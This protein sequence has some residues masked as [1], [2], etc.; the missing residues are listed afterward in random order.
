MRISAA[1]PTIVRIVR[2]LRRASPLAVKRRRLNA[3]KLID[4][5]AMLYSE[6]AGQRVDGLPRP[7]VGEVGVGR[8]LVVRCFRFFARRIPPMIAIAAIAPARPM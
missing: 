6:R 3:G 5:P 4:D 2:T 1:S 7:V 8:K